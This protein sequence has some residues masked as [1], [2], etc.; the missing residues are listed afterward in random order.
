[1]FSIARSQRGVSAGASSP[2]E[3][4][5]RRT[6]K[7]IRTTPSASSTQ[8]TVVFALSEPDPNTAPKPASSA[9]RTALIAPVHART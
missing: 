7:T 4:R 9:T 2:R 3:L 8:D 6:P 5:R 1:M